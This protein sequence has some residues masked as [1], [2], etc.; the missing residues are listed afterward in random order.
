MRLTAELIQDSLSYLNPLKERELD[1]RG[2]RIPAIENLGVA[3]PHDAIDFTD[4]DIQ[5]LGNFPLS[6]RLNTLLLARNR[7]ASIQPGLAKAVPNLKHLVLASNNMAE[8]A[9]LDVLGVFPRL[10]HL[11]L[12]DNPVTKKDVS[13]ASSPK[14]T[15]GNPGLEKVLL[16]FAVQHY[17]YWVLWRCPT[18]RFLDYEKV[19]QAER[20]QGRELFG[21]A[22][23]PTALAAQIMARKSKSL[24]TS[25]NGSAAPSKLSRIKL[26][27]EEK[28]RLQDRI[29]K[30][31][32][33]QEI[34]A[35]EKELNEG[36]VPSGIQ[37]DAM[38]E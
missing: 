36:R 13:V 9:D 16:M 35:L 7:I 37:G 31:T 12:A 4:N 21:T 3:G 19:K 11:V 23:E 30:A 8:L 27:D 1:L 29:K 34:I 33:L 24:E 32:S 15:D 2:Q 17:R 10:T 5:V 26:T 28:Q 20:D 14:A 38:E 22:E 18:V 6:P 25:V